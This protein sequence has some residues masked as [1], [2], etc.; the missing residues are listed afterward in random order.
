MAEHLTQAS[1]LLAAVLFI[2]SLRWLNHPSTARR[3]VAA[4]VAGMAAAIVGTLLDPEIVG[5]LW[6]V[7]AMVVGTA[8]GVPLSKVPLTAV[9]QR[10]ALSHAFGGLA[11]ALVGTAKYCLWLHE[12]ELTTFRTVAIAI[13][14]ILGGLTFTGSLMA[15]GKLQE[16][17]PTRPITY[18]GQNVINLSLLAIAV[19]VGDLP[20][21]SIRAGGGCSSSSWCCRWCSACC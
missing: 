10:T 5:Y 14:V 3:G 17:I 20:G 21:R 16:V 6:I 1:Y 4:G 11:A 18:T 8:I 7:V 12:G 13:E 19:V 2:L 15:A 9:P